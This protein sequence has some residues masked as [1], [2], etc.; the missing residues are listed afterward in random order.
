MSFNEAAAALP[1]KSAGL[2]CRT[3]DALWQD[4]FERSLSDQP[5]FSWRF[6]SG[7][8]ILGATLSLHNSNQRCERR[9]GC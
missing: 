3:R 4:I 7:A 1:R 2:V 6:R 9:A 8:T 5:A